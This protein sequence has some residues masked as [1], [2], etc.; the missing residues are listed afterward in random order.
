MPSARRPV[1]RDNVILIIGFAAV[2]GL[3]GLLTAISLRQMERQLDQLD[4][5][6]NGIMTKVEV[7]AH[8]HAIARQRTLSLQRMLIIDDPF[9][10]DEEWSRFTQQ[11]ALFIEARQRLQRM[12]LTAIEQRLL[13]EQTELSRQVAPLQTRAVDL[14]MQGERSQAASLVL[15]R[16][17]PLQDEVVDILETLFKEQRYRARDA[18]AEAIEVQYRA[19]LLIIGVALTTLALGGS[20]AYVVSRRI[21]R[22]ARERE[23]M[24]THDALTGLPNRVLVSDRIEQAILRAHRIERRA[25]VMFLDL[26]R[27][28]VINDTL[29]HQA[30][31]ELLVQVAKRLRGCVRRGD[32]VGR[33]GGDEFVVLIEDALAACDVAAVAGKII[34]ALGQPCTVAG[35]EVYAGVSIGIALYPESGEDVQSLLKNA[36][37]AMYHAKERG[38]NN[39]QIYTSAMSAAGTG[40]L[41]LE[42]ALRHAVERGEIVTHFQPQVD[43]HDGGIRRLETLVR[44]HHP[45]RGLVPPGE[46]LPVAEESGLILAIGEE[47]LRQACRQVRRW[48]DAGITGLR[49]AVN[50]SDPEFRHTGLIERIRRQLDETGLPPGQLEVELTEGVLMHNADAGAGLLHELKALGVHLSLDD[51]GTG[52]SSLGRLKGLPLDVIKIDRSFVRDLVRDPSDAAIIRAIVAMTDSLGFEVV[53]EGVET[54]EQLDFLRNLGCRRVQGYLISPPLPA[55]AL[56]DL[57][58]QGWRPA[59]QP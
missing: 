49:V 9:L 27:F 45:Q 51:F 17:I 24:A 40:R 11:A 2:L 3:M 57:L 47:V 25:A 28:K 34:A 6:V 21:H 19:R 44:W 5:I 53:A 36:D 12:P 43:L 59:M 8:M 46:F 58:L 10:R 26:D 41:A 35:N 22:A 52:Y 29:G 37:T 31:D 18:L 55:E 54:M 7:T 20:V 13:A 38:R 32:T 39:F 30:G 33:L 16:V 50:L 23:F 56:T 4:L 42:A 48:H 15:S 14:M 1:G